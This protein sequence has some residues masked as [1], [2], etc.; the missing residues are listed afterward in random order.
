MRFCESAFRCGFDVESVAA[1]ETGVRPEGLT[2]VTVKFTVVRCD[3][4]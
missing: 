2:A 3:A 1:R 4:V